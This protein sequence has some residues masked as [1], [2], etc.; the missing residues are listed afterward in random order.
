MFALL[1]ALVFDL[2]PD[3]PPTG[4][5]RLQSSPATA[6]QVPSAVTIRSA[7]FLVEAPEAAVARQVLGW[8]EAARG[9]LLRRW[10]GQPDDG[11]D[12]APPPWPRPVRIVVHR[13]HPG[14]YATEF[15]SDG[16]VTITLWAG[17]LHLHSTV[18]HEVCHAVLHL[19]YPGRLIPRWFDEGLAV[20]Q[21]LPEE[22]ERLVQPLLRSSHRFSTR[23]LF[24]MRDYPRDIALFYAQSYSL[25]DFLVT[26]HGERELLRFLEAAFTLG[27]EAALSHVLGYASI[28]A[29]DAAWWSSVRSSDPER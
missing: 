16:S 21:E 9:D 3:L 23:Q 18:R 27:Q 19:R 20:C 8:A 4:C 28:E 1:L 10:D 22:R 12:A 2:C 24:Q 13:R 26:R 11:D 7:N 25:V 29:L 15:G 5:V 14:F 17:D 6:A